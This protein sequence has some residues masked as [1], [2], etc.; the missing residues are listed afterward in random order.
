MALIIILG[1][2]FWGIIKNIIKDDAHQ[3]KALKD[4]VPFYHDNKGILRNTATNKPLTKKEYEELPRYQYNGLKQFDNMNKIRNAYTTFKIS[5][6]DYE[7][8]IKWHNLEKGLISRFDI[9]YA[10]KKRYADSYQSQMDRILK[11]CL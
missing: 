3:Y 11:K 5:R 7:E 10:Q 9:S 1:I 8:Y 2:L 4:G 6:E